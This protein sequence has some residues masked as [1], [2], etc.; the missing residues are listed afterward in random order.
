MAVAVFDADVLIAYLGGDDAHHAQ[1]VE[2]VR[3]ALEPGTRR[4]VSAVNY[5]EILIGPLESAGAAGA[6]TVDAMFVRFGIETIQV[7]MDLARRAAAVRARTNLK[8]PDAFALATAVHAEKRGHED[9]RIES[10]DKKV[11]K[12][13]ADLHPLS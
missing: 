2:R 1:A 4:L 5:S 3:R 6:E 10:F 8:L 9:V 7:D 13:F 11:N 12:A